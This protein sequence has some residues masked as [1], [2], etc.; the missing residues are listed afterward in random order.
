MKT[1]V[2]LFVICLIA[3][4]IFV[5]YTKYESNYDGVSIAIHD[6]TDSYGL[7]AKYNINNTDKVQQYI[8]S[9]LAPNILFPSPNDDLDVNTTLKDGTYFTIKSSPG[10]MKIS[11]DKT[12]NSTRS[13]YRIKKMCDG[14]KEVLAGKK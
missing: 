3:L 8:N 4:S 13:Y 11:I 5:G 1:S 12:K 7:I 6:D 9:C 10:N 14:I 2:Y